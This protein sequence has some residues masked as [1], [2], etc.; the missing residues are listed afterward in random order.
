MWQKITFS[1]RWQLLTHVCPRAQPASWES[2][3]TFA[4]SED[5]LSA[6]NCVVIFLHFFLAPKSFFSSHCLH[7]HAPI[8]LHLCYLHFLRSES[9]STCTV[10]TSYVDRHS[11]S[12][13]PTWGM[14]R[15]LVEKLTIHTC[16]DLIRSSDTVNILINYDMT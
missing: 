13:L 3:P 9:L 12:D 4:C 8:V 10:L 14:E 2:Q 6:V 15:K 11:F 1:Q 7:I 16:K 5:I